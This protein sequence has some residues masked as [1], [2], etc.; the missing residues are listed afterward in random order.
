VFFGHNQMLSCRYAALMATMGIALVVLF[1]LSSG[2]FTATHGPVSALRAIANFALLLVIF[3]FLAA[4][5]RG[6]LTSCIRQP[7]PFEPTEA[8]APWPILELRC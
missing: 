2:P 8:C 1:P 5:R 7:I 6:R 3:C 4:Q